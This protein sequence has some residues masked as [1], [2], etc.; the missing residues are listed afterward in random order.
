MSWRETLG[1]TRLV[2]QPCAQNSHKTQKSSNRGISAHSANSAL[3]KSDEST[4]SLKGSLSAICREVSI[5]PITVHNAL[6]PKD[7]EDWHQGK[8]DHRALA[9]FAQS[10]LQRQQMNRGERPAHYT[11]RAICRHC[12]PIWLWFSGEVLGCPWCWNRKAGRPIPRPDTT[13]DRFGQ[14]YIRH[15][16]GSAEEK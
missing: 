14:Q 1:A 5:E 11:E 2:R 15:S 7:I 3:E 6:A 4:S 13:Y 16:T 9:T 8:I 12:G 10:L